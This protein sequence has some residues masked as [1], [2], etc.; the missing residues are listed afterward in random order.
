MADKEKYIKRI[1]IHYEAKSGKRIS[2]SE[3]LD[4]FE[5]LVTLVSAVYK[6]IPKKLWTTMKKK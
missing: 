6:P 5:K 4:I 3:A 1:K 2:D